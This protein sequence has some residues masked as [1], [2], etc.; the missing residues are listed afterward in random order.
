ME[1]CS[2]DGGVRSRVL[3]PVATI[4][5]TREGQAWRSPISAGVNTIGPKSRTPAWC[6]MRNLGL[7]GVGAAALERVCGD[8]ELPDMSSL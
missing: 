7:L 5:S 1:R 2:L 8:S 6:M 3:L 4:P